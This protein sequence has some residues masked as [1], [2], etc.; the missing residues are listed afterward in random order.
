MWTTE[1]RKTDV[2]DPKGHPSNLTDQEWAVLEP[3]IPS[4]T[5]GGRPRKSDKRARRICET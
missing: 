3:L 4:A 1:H 5:P 2:R